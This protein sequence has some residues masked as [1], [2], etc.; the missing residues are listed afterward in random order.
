MNVLMHTQAH[1]K[2]REEVP[3]REKNASTMLG[4]DVFSTD[5]MPTDKAIFI[6]NKEN[7]K[8]V[9][10]LIEREGFN[11]AM[12]ICSMLGWVSKETRQ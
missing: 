9:I 8:P 11:R 2:I 5:A 12:K 1:Q 4:I 3:E 7:I 6:P 10:E